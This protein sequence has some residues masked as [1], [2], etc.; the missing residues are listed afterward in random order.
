MLGDHRLRLK[1]E[2]VDSFGKPLAELLDDL[3]ATMRAAPGVGLAA[4]QLGEPLRACVV[5]VESKLYELVNPSIVRAER[6]RPRPGGLPLDPGLR[7]LRH[8]PREG[9]GRRPEPDGKKVK[10]AGRACSAAPS[11]TS[12]ITSTAMPSRSASRAGAPGPSR[13]DPETL[14]FLPVR[15]WATTQTRSWRVT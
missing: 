13:P 14:Y 3:T 10:V 12:S 11:S 8:A 4:P 7:R 5:E 6:R 15:F 9:V 1:G 2:T